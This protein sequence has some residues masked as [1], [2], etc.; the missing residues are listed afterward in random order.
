MKQGHGVFYFAFGAAALMVTGA[1]A[2]SE[3]ATSPEKPAWAAEAT[4][5]PDYVGS[6]APAAPA[7]PPGDAAAPAATDDAASRAAEEEAATEAK[8]KADQEAEAAADKAAQDAE[9][10]R[11]AEQE[12]A[13]AKAKAEAEAAAAAKA[14]EEAEAQRQAEEKAVAEKAAAD[15]EAKR[16][17][18]EAAAKAEA[19][20]K[21][22]QAIEGCR[23]SLNAE[24]TASKFSFANESWAV[25]RSGRA[26]LDKIVG[27]IADCGDVTIEVG[28]HT[29]SIGSDASNK[30]IS[31]LR[32]D[33][34]VATLKDKGVDGS[35]LTAVGYGKE[36]PVASNDSADGRRQNRRIEFLVTAR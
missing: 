35:K 17:A 13:E 25:S 6:G 32:A 3:N 14:A 26:V 31:Q 33:A 11:K 29:D 23:D 7:T 21:L 27:I 20:A 10:Q 19:E 8:R 34:V 15:A 30:R 9:A 2:Q 36:K 4:M 28:G 12:A 22:Q 5:N 24:V 16:L 18:D 1:Q